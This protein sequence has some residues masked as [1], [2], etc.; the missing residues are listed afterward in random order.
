MREYQFKG[1]FLYYVRLLKRLYEATL[2]A[3]AEQ[4]GLTLPEADVLSFL[5]ENHEFDTSKDVALYREVS[6]PYVSKAVEL[7]VKRGYLEVSQDAKDRRLQH[8]R[9]TTAANQAANILHKAQFSF[10][11]K[12]TSGL[13]N[14]ELSSMLTAVEKCAAN[15]TE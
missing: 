14:E 2:T 13:S 8:L 10:Y 11:D 9:I 5:R 4:C 12:V 7:L 6:R 15:L 1:N 3:A